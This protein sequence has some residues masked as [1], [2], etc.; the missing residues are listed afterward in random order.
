MSKQEKLSEDD[1]M[2][3]QDLIKKFFS[4]HEYEPTDKEV[5]NALKCM[6]KK[7]FMEYV[8][9]AENDMANGRYREATEVFDGLEQ[10]YGF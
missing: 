9:V 6:S 2:K 7:D 8:T 1:L 5:G 3:I 4:Q 10:R